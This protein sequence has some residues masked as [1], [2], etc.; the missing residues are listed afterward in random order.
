MIKTFLTIDKQNFRKLVF[1][2]S[3]YNFLVMDKLVLF[4]FTWLASSCMQ[5][6][7]GRAIRKSELAS[8]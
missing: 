2:G 5:V 7:M 4:F 1:G 8:Q 6:G 3:K